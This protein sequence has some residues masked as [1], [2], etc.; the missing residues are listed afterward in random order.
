M[1]ELLP[2]LGANCPAG[3]S[4]QLVG[5]GWPRIGMPMSCIEYVPAGQTVCART[6]PTSAAAATAADSRDIMIEQ[7]LVPAASASS[8]SCAKKPCAAAGLRPCSC[9]LD[10]MQHAPLLARAN[11]KA[12]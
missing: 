12:L 4:T 2:A 9:L 7:L 3:Q 10:V 8:R 5:G 1:H 6:A 11:N